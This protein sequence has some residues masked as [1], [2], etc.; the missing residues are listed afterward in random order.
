MDKSWFS[1]N[2]SLNEYCKKSTMDSIKKKVEYYNLERN[3]PNLKFTLDINQNNDN[4]GDND[5]GDNDDD[6]NDDNKNKP[7][8]NLYTF[9]GFL[10]ISTIAILIYKRKNNMFS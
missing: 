9:I 10:S 2:K 5:N 3:K 4:N 7:I 6:D 1:Y 8:L